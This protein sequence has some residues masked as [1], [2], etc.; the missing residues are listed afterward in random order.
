MIVPCGIVSLIQ[1]RIYPQIKIEINY[2]GQT[3]GSSLTQP[4][5]FYSIDHFGQQIEA[6][7]P[8]YFLIAKPSTSSSIRANK[9]VC[10]ANSTYGAIVLGCNFSSYPGTNLTLNFQTNIQ[11]F[12]INGSN[13]SLNIAFKQCNIGEIIPSNSDICSICPPNTYS[14]T[15][16]VDSSTICNSCDNVTGTK[17]REGGSALTVKSEYWRYNESSINVI[18]CLNQDACSPVAQ[19]IINCSSFSENVKKGGTQE[20]CEKYESAIYAGTNPYK[21][22]SFETQNNISNFCSLMVNGTKTGYCNEAKGY[23]RDGVLCTECIEGWEKS[24]NYECIQCKPTFSF[25]ASMIIVGVFKIGLITYTVSRAREERRDHH[26]STALRILITFFQIVSL[27]FSIPMYWPPFF[28]I[29][30]KFLVSFFSSGVNPGGYSYD[31]ILYWMNTSKR[32]NYFI[33]NALYSFFAPV[34]WTAAASL[35]LPI[36]KFA[37]K[38]QMSWQSFKDILK[39]T[40][41]VTYFYFWPEM[42]ANAFNMFNF[43]NIGPQNASDL[44]L[45]VDPTIA[46][47]SPDHWFILFFGIPTLIVSGICLPLLLFFKLRKNDNPIEEQQS[48]NS[49][50]FFYRAYKDEH[51]RWEFVILLRK[52]A[53]VGASVFLVRD[54]NYMCVTLSVIIVVSAVLQLYCLPFKSRELNKLELVALLCLVTINYGSIY[55]VNLGTRLSTIFYI[56]LAMISTIVFIIMWIRTIKEYAR[57]KFTSICQSIKRL[58]AKCCTRLKR[59]FLCC[60]GLLYRNKSHYYINDTLR[61]QELNNEHNSVKISI[62]TNN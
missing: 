54:I 40:F 30:R 28:D 22:C 4:P 52:M 59:V 58:L 37:L 27:L 56:S 31:C 1:A 11:T 13:I 12:L 35:I 48:I 49:Y 43:F 19:N 20:T 62:S 14:L 29:F 44:R 42:I 17:C 50:D 2:F 41:L 55:H 57:D 7:D 33:Y 34:L 36:R 45:L 51:C 16:A 21:Q 39:L 60:F 23:K 25:F 8:E 18:E 6:D 53:L 9:N 46:V 24:R 3:G 10:L 61:T 26:H 38:N 5:I 32:L 15:Q 47:G